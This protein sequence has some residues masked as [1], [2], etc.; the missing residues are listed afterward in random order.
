MVGECRVGSARVRLTPE[1]PGG[2][3]GWGPLGLKDTVPPSEAVDQMY[4]TAVAL[5]DA[6]GERVVVVNADLCW[7]SRLIWED[8]AARTDLD[9]SRLILCGS[10]THQGPTHRCGALTRAA[11]LGTVRP[12]ATRSRKAMCTRAA[13]I[14]YS[15]RWVRSSGLPMRTSTIQ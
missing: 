6:G 7:G 15:R 13:T 4:A 8:A 10:H 5:E 3:A 2:T 1:S 11:G 14:P 12:L 9:P